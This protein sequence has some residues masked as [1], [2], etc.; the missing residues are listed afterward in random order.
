MRTL[1]LTSTA[2]SFVVLLAGAISG[3]YGIAVFGLTTLVG[4]ILADLGVFL[5]AAAPQSTAL[6]G[7][8]P[9]RMQADDDE[10]LEERRAA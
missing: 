2:V 4:S 9:V 5:G 6:L 8:P 10:V 7:V 1:T 3:E